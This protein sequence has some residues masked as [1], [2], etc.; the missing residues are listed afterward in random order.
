MMWRTVRIGEEAY[1]YLKELAKNKKKSL[2]S[3]ASEVI[4][5]RA[6]GELGNKALLSILIAER[7]QPSS[8]EEGIPRQG[9]NACA[10][11]MVQVVY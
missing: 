6:K 9:W 1:N 10:E 3:V 11:M 2:G 8:E 5:E 4:T 7:K